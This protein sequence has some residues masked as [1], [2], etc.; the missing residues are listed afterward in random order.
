VIV[1]SGGIPHVAW[2]HVLPDESGNSVVY[3]MWTGSGF[4][5][6]F[7]IS[8]WTFTH[9]PLLGLQGNTVYVLWQEGSWEG[10][11]LFY[12][13]G[14]GS[15]WSGT[16]TVPNSDGAV[17]MDFAFD[18]QGKMGF[19]WNSEGQIYYETTAGGGEPPRVNQP[20]VA[21]FSFSPSGGF[22][23]VEI[24]FDGTASSDPDG[25]VASWSWLFG[26]GDSASGSKV[27]HT[28]Q[29]Q[30]LYQV[31]LTVTDNEG[32]SASTTQSIEILGIYP[33]LNVRWTTFVD[34]SIFMS[35]YVTEVTWE[36]N[37]ANDRYNIVRHN[38]YRRN[39]GTNE[40]WKYIGQTAANIFRFLDTN[41]KKKDA[42]SY[43]V[44]AVDDQGHESRIG[45]AGA[46]SSVTFVIKDKTGTPVRRGPIR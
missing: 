39:V 11:T 2:S 41:V 16:S 6:P 29:N 17:Y 27:F 42:Y 25:M 46:S 43:A 14:R 31:K 5:A 24:Q 34:E 13:R 23:P 33:P 45:A 3:S 1:D 10:G 44:T 18:P 22:A 7:E 38:I 40:G 21:R 8:G 28:Y 9:W 26:D 32:L 36:K 19:V 4:S 35:R 37:F 30:G 20:P 15:D 12:R